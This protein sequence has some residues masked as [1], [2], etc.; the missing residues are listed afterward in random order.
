MVLLKILRE[1][2]KNYLINEGFNARIID[3]YRKNKILY[4]V[5]IGHYNTAQAAKE[6]GN[7]IKSKVGL[8]TIVVTNK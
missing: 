2:Q 7:Q 4:A 3:L 1:K 6:T 8:D 5:R